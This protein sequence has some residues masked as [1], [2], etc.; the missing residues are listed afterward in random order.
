MVLK[1]EKS[2]QKKNDCQGN[3]DEKDNAED[4]FQTGV[5]AYFRAH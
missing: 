4:S 2:C 3:A 5:T 1:K